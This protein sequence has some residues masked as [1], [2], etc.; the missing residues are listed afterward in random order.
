[1]NEPVNICV[2]VAHYMGLIVLAQHTILNKGIQKCVRQMYMHIFV[3]Y[4]YMY[5]QILAAYAYMQVHLHADIA[6]ISSNIATQGF[7]QA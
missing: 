5:T 4:L 3:P 6:A 1:M 2:K 7:A